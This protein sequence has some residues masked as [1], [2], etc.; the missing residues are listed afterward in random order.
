MYK[1]DLH[2]HSVASH[3]GGISAEQYRKALDNRTLD[4][5]AIT[6]HGGIDFGLQLRQE[7]GERIIVGQEIMTSA[8]E[9]IGLF[10]KK[11]ISD[12]LSTQQTIK[13][14]K[15]QGGLVY[16]PHPFETVRHGLHP[17]VLDELVDYIDI[18]EVVNGR[19]FLQN[20]SQQAVIWA[21]LNHKIGVASS[22][23][24]GWRGIGRTFTQT[25]NQPTE[26][27]LLSEL[28]RSNPIIGRPKIHDL[29]YPKLNKFKKKLVR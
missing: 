18:V 7:L 1:I 9:I 12:G 21:K 22:D 3:D 23:A 28:S 14:I 5:I 8:G 6:D 2:T 27:N 20:R 11:K 26:S 4:V 17:S 10:L 24:H 25:P 16:I 13:H 29:L 19:A 15:D